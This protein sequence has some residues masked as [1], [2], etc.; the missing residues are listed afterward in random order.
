MFSLALAL[1]DSRKVV[2]ALLRVGAVGGDVGFL[3]TAGRLHHT[4]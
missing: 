4:L 1:K 2:S 3:A